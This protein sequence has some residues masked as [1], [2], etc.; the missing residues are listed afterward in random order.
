MFKNQEQIDGFKASGDRTAFMIPEY[1]LI[2]T[3]QDDNSLQVQFSG[4]AYIIKVERKATNFGGHYYFFNCPQC[5]TRMRKLY[6]IDGRYLCRKKTCG[7]LGYYSQKLNFYD[8]LSYMQIKIE[9]TLKSKGGSLDR[10]P[11]WM[12]IHTF[13]ALKFQRK[14]YEARAYYAAEVEFAR[15]TGHRSPN[16]EYYLPR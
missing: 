10:K 14:M 1:E 8:R 4:G 13:E 2:T 7:N 11:P 5:S 3:L 9:A 15:Q 6:C 16:I 12:K